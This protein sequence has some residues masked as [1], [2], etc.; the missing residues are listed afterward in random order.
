MLRAARVNEETDR[1]Y[2]RETDTTGRRRVTARRP[3]VH[4]RACLRCRPS[5]QASGSSDGQLV[6]YKGDF[7]SWR[8]AAARQ[9]SEVGHTFVVALSD[10]RLIDGNLGSNSARFLNHACTPNCEAIE[11]GDPVLIHATTPIGPG[12]DLPIE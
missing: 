1:P 5:P 11:T 4:G 6:E 7:T 10:G 9:R 12:E 8:R 2:E 3:P